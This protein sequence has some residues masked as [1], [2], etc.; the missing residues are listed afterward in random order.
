MKIKFLKSLAILFFL[1]NCTQYSVKLGEKCTP[2][3]Y[4]NSYEKSYIWFV[5][6]DIEQ[7]FDAKITKKNCEKLENS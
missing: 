2:I 4:G 6:K 5:K 7:E 1:T 3:A